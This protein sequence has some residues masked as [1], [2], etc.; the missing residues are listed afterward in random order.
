[1]FKLHCFIANLISLLPLPPGV[2]KVGGLHQTLSFLHHCVSCHRALELRRHV[3][4]NTNLVRLGA[5]ALTAGG[6]GGKERSVGVS[7]DMLVTWVGHGDCG[8][9]GRGAGGGL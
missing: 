7:D 1:M 5:S 9:L 4:K 6:P 3:P 2:W 8:P